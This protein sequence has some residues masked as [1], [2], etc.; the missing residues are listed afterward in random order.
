MKKL[1]FISVLLLVP[2][3]ALAVGEQTFN[4]SFTV[5][6][7]VLDSIVSL[8]SSSWSEFVNTFKTSSM[9]SITS[10]TI[11]NDLNID[12][13]LVV[14]TGESFGGDYSVDFSTWTPHIA[15]IKAIFIITSSYSAF[16]IVTRGG[17]Q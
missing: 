17:S 13:V 15:V 5:P 1:L 14:S 3:V 7:G 12:P 9:Y 6:T 2:S 4:G 16:K 10:S 8:F 11:M